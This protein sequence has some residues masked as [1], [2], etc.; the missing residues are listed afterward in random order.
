MNWRSKLKI[1]A[2]LAVVALAVAYGFMPRP[3]PVELEKAALKPMRVTIEEEGKTRIKDT[4]VVSAPVSGYMRRLE[5]KV[6]D[7]VARDQAL[8]ELEPL[9]STVLDPRTKAQAEARVKAAQAALNAAQE[10]AVAVRAEANYAEIKLERTRKLFSTGHVARDELDQ[11]EAQARQIKATLQSAELAVQ[12]SRFE[13]EEART[14]LKY[15]QAEKPENPSRPVSV[16]A[17]A[18]GL[19]LKIYRQSEGSVAAGEPLLEIG[20]PRHLEVKVD[21]LSDDAVRLKPGLPVLFDRWGGGEPLT[22]VVRRIEPI[23]F[24]KVSAL[25]VEEQRVLVVADIT[26]PPETW[27]RLGEGYRVLARF[28]LWEADK[29]LQIPSSALFRYNQGWAVFVHQNGRAVKKPVQ[30]GHRSGLVTEIVSGLS[31]G[32]EV[33]TH[34]DDAISDGGRVSAKK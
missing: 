16:Q 18:A 20:D 31:S 10:K 33:I 25:G 21:V 29:V 24:T 28:V 32:A 26:S 9:R 8:V 17:P 27:T 6:G 5:L 4:F 13:L 11:A 2:F 19:V 15:Q 3:V 30:I 34:P 14:V 7:P 12:V 22:G 23:G 1:L